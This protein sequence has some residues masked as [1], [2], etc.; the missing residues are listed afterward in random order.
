MPL[1][2]FAFLFT[3]YYQ[4]TATAE[5]A[6]EFIRLAAMDEHAVELQRLLEEAW[7]RPDA[8]PVFS[9]AES[10]ALLADVLRTGRE[11]Q[12]GREAQPPP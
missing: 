11:A 12:E 1:T 9:E 7:V 6:E 3:K 2:R 10:E 5:E 4:K 8:T